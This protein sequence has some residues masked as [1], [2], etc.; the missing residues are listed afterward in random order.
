MTSIVG[1]AEILLDE[2][3]DPMTEKI[4]RTIA[5]NGERL[6]GLCNDLLAIQA[7]DVRDPDTT[8]RRVEVPELL[9]QLESAVRAGTRGRQL[10]LAFQAC[11]DGVAVM[12]DPDQLD[13]MLA[14]LLSNAV[15]FTPDG[16]RVSLGVDAEPAWVHVSVTDTGIG[17]PPEDRDQLFQRFFRSR[18]VAELQIQGTGLGLSIVASIVE[19][20]GGT[21]E[22]D[23]TLG[24]GTTFTVHLPRAD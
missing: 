18:N 4:L 3:P 22:V 7:M 16:G 10:D 15:K 2:E 11:P 20:H 8:H 24:E 1:Y 5:R 21:I 19:S 6:I 9:A 14:N 23:S 12:G 13:R 17:I